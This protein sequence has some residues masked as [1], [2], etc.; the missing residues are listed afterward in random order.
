MKNIYH[1]YECKKYMK[2]PKHTI[3][4][5]DETK[6]QINVNLQIHKFAN[7]RI[8]SGVQRDTETT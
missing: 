2:Y 4:L 7:V 5:A 1:L 8:I 3:H 6:S